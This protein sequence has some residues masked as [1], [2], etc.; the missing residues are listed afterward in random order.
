MLENEARLT[1]LAARV[2]EKRLQKLVKLFSS[3]SVH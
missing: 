3:S 1:V 2:E